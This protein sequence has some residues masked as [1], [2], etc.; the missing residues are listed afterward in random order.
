[1]QHTSAEAVPAP[2]GTELGFEE[3]FD[4]D[5]L[6]GTGGE[7]SEEDIAFDRIVGVLESIVM[8]P[9]FR[10]TH[11]HFCKTHCGVFEYSDENKLEYTTIFQQYTDVTETYIDRRLREEIPGFVMDDFLVML[12]SRPEEIS[13]DLFDLLLGFGDFEEF[14]SLMLSYKE[15]FGGG[16]TLSPKVSR[17][18]PPSR[19]VPSPV[20]VPAPAPVSASASAPASGGAGAGTPDVT[21]LPDSVA[22]LTLAEGTP[23]PVVLGCSSRA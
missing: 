9:V 13:G 5:D 4:D 19:L 2:T 23:S 21:L 10:S 20:L 17:Y 11:E 1:M 18:D 22:A 8:D 16:V 6:G 7:A 15:Q 12:E 3:D 14:K